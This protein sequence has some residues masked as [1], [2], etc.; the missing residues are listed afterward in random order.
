ML[1]ASTFSANENF[2]LYFSKTTFK[3]G[4]KRAFTAP[5]GV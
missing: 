3:A 5:G 2:I 1:D 4:F